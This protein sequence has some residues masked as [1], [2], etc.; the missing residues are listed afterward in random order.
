MIY[1]ASLLVAHLLGWT[2]ES[3][4]ISGPTCAI[5][6][7]GGLGTCFA[8][9][10]GIRSVIWTDVLQFF[11]LFG[12][13]LVMGLIAIHASG[14]LT[15]ALSV[16]MQQG[17]FHPPQWFSPTEELTFA[18]ALSLGFFGYLS[19]AGAD[20]V[21]M[22]TY[23][24]AKSADEA[25]SSL[26][27]NGFLFKPLS[28]LFPALGLF[29]FVYYRAHPEVALLLRVPDDALP[30]FVSYVL[31][32]GIRGLMIAAIM[33]AV[34][35]GLASGMTA[36]TTCVQVDFVCRWKKNRLS[37]ASAVRLAR[38]LVLVWGNHGNRGSHL[39]AENRRFKQY[40]AN[41]QHSHVPVCRSSAGSFSAGIVDA[42]H[43][44]R[45][46]GG[47]GNLRFYR[48]GWRPHTESTS[49]LFKHGSDA[50]PGFFSA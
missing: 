8:L 1:A 6:L 49:A 41:P 23:L 21:L 19:N 42:T 45:R 28:L 9:A 44:F 26:L 50:D 33:A 15:H 46:R 32:S 37:D 20:Q 43:Q 7:L 22:Q 29:L 30:V 5:L 25:K 38:C 48:Y 35:S 2:S 11:V 47:G 39:G 17:K 16:A 14:G 31:P 27:R 18:S 12:G 4:A 3:G 13:V 24:T 40:R 36:L 34:L 10:G